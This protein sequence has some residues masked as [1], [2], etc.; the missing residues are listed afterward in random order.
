MYCITH[1]ISHLIKYI[2]FH[3]YKNMK[4]NIGVN[5]RILY[6]IYDIYENLLIGNCSIHNVA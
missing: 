6:K 4:N 3:L 5:S 2:I 1:S